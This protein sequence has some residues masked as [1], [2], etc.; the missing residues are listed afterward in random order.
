M[1]VICYSYNVM[2]LC[3]VLDVYLE[4]PPQC[5]QIAGAIIQETYLWSKGEIVVADFLS[6][7]ACEWSQLGEAARQCYL[8]TSSGESYNKETK[9]TAHLFFHVIIAKKLL[10]LA[11]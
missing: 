1:A 4:S 3:A 9:Y 10:F 8:G 2:C 6:E 5:N 11:S 7:P